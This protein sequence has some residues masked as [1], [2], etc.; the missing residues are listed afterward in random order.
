MSAGGSGVKTDL[1]PKFVV[2][3]VQAALTSE[4]DLLPFSSTTWKMTFCPSFSPLS[5][6]RSTTD[7]CTKTSPSEDSDEPETLL[8]VEPFDRADT[9]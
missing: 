1:T 5:P 6:A 9:A 4:A 8:G 2:E 7:I 3:M